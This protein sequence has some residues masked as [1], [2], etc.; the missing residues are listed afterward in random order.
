MYLPVTKERLASIAIH[1]EV[2]FKKPQGW[3]E[4]I[5][6]NGY[7][8]SFA[9]CMWKPDDNMVTFEFMHY[10]LEKLILLMTKTQKHPVA[11]KIC[12]AQVFSVFFITIWIYALFPVAMQII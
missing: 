1:K 4:W 2:W 5:P 11:M 8:I 3:T 12:I 7:V 10:F 9:I 6:W